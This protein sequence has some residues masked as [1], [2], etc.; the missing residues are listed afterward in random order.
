MSMR[1]V[2]ILRPNRVRMI[3]KPFAWIP[4][5]L[6]TDGLLGNLS[7]H[8]KA[9]YF[10]LCLVADRDGVSFYGDKR[11]QMLL[12]FETADL[13]EARAQLI[14]NDLVAYDGRIYQVLSLPAPPSP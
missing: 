4:F 14:D 13:G 8:A 2:K 7:I 10:F 1:H 5:R 3:E 11:I 12:H 9:L 6:L